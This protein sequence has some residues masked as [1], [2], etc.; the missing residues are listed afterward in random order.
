M[1]KG[2]AFHK[3]NIVIKSVEAT[4]EFYC[5]EFQLKTIQARPGLQF[6]RSELP[7]AVTYRHRLSS[8]GSRQ[9]PAWIPELVQGLKS[10][11]RA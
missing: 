7:F 8:A 3:R 2:S 1:V 10:G 9:W 5:L 6:L 11:R 4:L